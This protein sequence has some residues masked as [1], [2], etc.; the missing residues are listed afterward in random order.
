VSEKRKRLEVIQRLEEL[1]EE[2]SLTRADVG[3][4]LGTGPSTVT[5]WIRGW[6]APPKRMIRRIEKFIDSFEDGVYEDRRDSLGDA[7]RHVVDCA[8]YEC[9]T[10]RVFWNIVEEIANL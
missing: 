10:C 8:D 3:N 1:I 9:R 5:N 4:A 7:L 6:H 2:E